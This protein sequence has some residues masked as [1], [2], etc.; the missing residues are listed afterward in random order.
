MNG[1]KDT[2]ASHIGTFGDLIIC[3]KLEECKKDRRIKIKSTK[4]TALIDT[5]QNKESRSEE[6]M[7]RN[8]CSTC[9]SFQMIECIVASSF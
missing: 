8:T 4:F 9:A 6:P 5:S 3:Y 2:I 1:D 7:T